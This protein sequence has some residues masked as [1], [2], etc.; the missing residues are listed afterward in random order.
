MHG[1]LPGLAAG[2]F[3]VIMFFSAYRLPS[4]ASDDPRRHM[5]PDIKSLPAGPPPTMASELAGFGRNFRAGMH[6]MVK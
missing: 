1:S 5:H 3:G 6:S 2:R 4:F